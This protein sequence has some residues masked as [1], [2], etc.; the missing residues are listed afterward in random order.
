MDQTARE[1]QEYL[2]IDHGYY[3][4]NKLDIIDINKGG[5]I[6]Y[7]SQYTLTH[8]VRTSPEAMLCAHWHKQ[9]IRVRDRRIFM[10]VNPDFFWSVVD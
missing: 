5:G 6:V 1:N 10:D 8:I 4:I 9:S 3:D 7:I 2:I